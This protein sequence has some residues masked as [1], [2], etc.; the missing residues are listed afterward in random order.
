MSKAE[1][2][3]G[4]AA[5]KAWVESALRECDGHEHG[6]IADLAQA[7]RALITHLGSDADTADVDVLETAAYLCRGHG[8][9]RGQR[10]AIG[11]GVALALQ[12]ERNQWRR[13]LEMQMAAVRERFGGPP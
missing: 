7:V 10:I 1:A 6:A 9:D 11:R 5:A 13:K 12:T 8:L 3:V 2:L 4:L